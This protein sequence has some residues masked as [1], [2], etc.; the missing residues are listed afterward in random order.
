MKNRYIVA[1]GVIAI[2]GTPASA[3][4]GKRRTRTVQVEQFTAAVP[5]D[6]TQD[7]IMY[8]SE[9][10]GGAPHG[11]IEF[12]ATEMSIDG[13]TVKGAPY[14]AEAITE[15]SQVLGDG[16]RISRKTQ[17]SVARDSEGRTRREA[18]LPGIGPWATSGTAPKHVFINDPVEGVNY[19]LDST[20]K[21]ARKLPAAK[22]I[23]KA[24]AAAHQEAHA[25]AA[26][27]MTAGR[28]VEG[29][30]K[31]DVGVTMPR[32]A[33]EVFGGKALEAKREDLGKRN[34]EGVPCDGTRTTVT[35]PAGE[36]GNERPI[37]ITDERWFSP[38]LQ[39]IVMSRHSDPRTGETI[40][41]LD[42]IQRSEP[43]KSLF[44]VPAGYS[45]PDDGMLRKLDELRRKG[46]TF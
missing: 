17:S 40:Y 26:G 42:S 19:I 28:R 35:I 4:E 3:Q 7:H 1:A 38:E 13:R 14:S 11:T 32:I 25:E 30:L 12:I 46:D 6:T 5:A 23:S 15:T 29:G 22:I 31:A 20:N 16:N 24:R 37:D 9:A 27:Q 45:V 39:V 33:M 36:I 34:I 18:S 41:K 8:R 21:T 43:L 10:A 44:E 2:L